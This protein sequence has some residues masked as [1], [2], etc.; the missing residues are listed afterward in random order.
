MPITSEPKGPKPPLTG[1]VKLQFLW[2]QT[3]TGNPNL[4]AANILHVKWSDNANHPVADLQLLATDAYT[5]MYTLAGSHVST[6][7]KLI[8]CVASSLGGD[9][10]AATTT[11]STAGTDSGA[12]LP[13]QCAVVVTWKAA[14]FWRGGKPRTYL[15]FFTEN[16][17][18][19][20]VGGGSQLA[21][22]HTAALATAAD[23]MIADFA[24]LTIGGAHPVLGF[25]SY[26][27]KGAFRPVPIFYPFVSA[28]VHDRMDSQRRRSGKESIFPID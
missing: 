27:S 1:L 12:P 9:G 11:T 23:T 3:L 28:V 18:S 5:E 7:A 4:Q 26:Y 2:Q 20:S 8:G 10:L 21:S 22:V 25:P 14:I 24:A 19:S 17:T 15:P 13:P 6:T 16:V